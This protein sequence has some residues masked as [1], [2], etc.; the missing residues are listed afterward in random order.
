MTAIRVKSVL[1]AA[2]TEIKQADRGYSVLGSLQKQILQCEPEAG[3]HGAAVEI[4]SDLENS[5]AG[6]GVVQVNFAGTRINDPDLTYA[7]AKVILDLL[8]HLFRGVGQADDLDREIG[9][10]FPG[11]GSRNAASQRPAL[12]RDKGQVGPALEAKSGVQQ[13]KGLGHNTPQLI[14]MGMISHPAQQK[15]SEKRLNDTHCWLLHDLP[16]N[17]FVESDPGRFQG[18]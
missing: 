14:L 16:A 10:D 2:G 3:K 12:G 11:L 18:W 7:R 6:R 5:Y 9:N 17:D 4:V 13:K 1:L 15:G 8:G